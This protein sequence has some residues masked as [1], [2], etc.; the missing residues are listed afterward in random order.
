V[1]TGPIHTTV[2]A[3]KDVLHD[4]V[5]AAEQVGVNAGHDVTGGAISGGTVG[6]RLVAATLGVL[7]AEA[8]GVPHAHGLS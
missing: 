7:L 1:E 4:S 3:F 2:V 8:G 6:G 5:S